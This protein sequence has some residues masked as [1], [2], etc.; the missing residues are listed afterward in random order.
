M[1]K[2]TL[3]R[4][5]FLAAGA[6]LG[7]A[8]F[9]ARP[10]HAASQGPW[11]EIA[12][13][14]RVIEVKGKAATVFGLR[15]PDGAHGLIMDAGDRFRVR[16]HNEIAESALIHWHGLTP[17]NSEDGVPGVTQSPLNPGEIHEY[18]FAVA[19]PGTNW[20]H[21]HHVLQE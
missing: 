17:P 14:T 10:L 21:S 13:S 1:M 8:A 5:H 15:Q 2:T 11:T 12:I 7:A 9:G 6:S 20:M 18:D 3:S 19:L 4:R 16:L